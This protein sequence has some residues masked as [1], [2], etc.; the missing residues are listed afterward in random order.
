MEATSPGAVTAQYGVYVEPGSPINATT[1]YGVSVGDSAEIDYALDVSGTNYKLGQMKV[2]L[3]SASG[4]ARANMGFGCTYNSTGA[5]IL[6]LHKD[7][8]D[9]NKV[10][11]V[12]KDGSDFYYV[13]TTACGA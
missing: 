1:V 2:P 3:S 10:Y 6:G 4:K 9:S 7:T 5:A 8:S 13:L 12:V 11:I